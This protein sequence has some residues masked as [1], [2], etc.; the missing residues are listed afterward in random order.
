M[1]EYTIYTHLHYRGNNFI[2]DVV[3]INFLIYN[4]NKSAFATR[5]HA[6]EVENN[7]SGYY[8]H[9]MII[10]YKIHEKS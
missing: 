10:K 1:F 9:T 8:E 4:N 7:N 6:I 3:A 2:D 5:L